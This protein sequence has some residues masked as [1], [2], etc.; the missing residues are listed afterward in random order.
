MNDQKSIMNALEILY[1]NPGNILSINQNAR[2][3][4]TMKTCILSACFIILRHIK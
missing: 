4:K 3:L 1:L 2:C